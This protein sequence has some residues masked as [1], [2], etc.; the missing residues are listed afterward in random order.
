MAV[1]VAVAMAV[2]VGVGVAVVV[3]VVVL[4]LWLWELSGIA[5]DCTDT[6]TITHHHS[7]VYLRVLGGVRCG[8]VRYIVLAGAVRRVS[9][10]VR[11][12][13]WGDV[14]ILSLPPFNGVKMCQ[15]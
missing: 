3:A 7:A 9:G 15:K 4:W 11:R 5:I 2:G 12:R 1:A 14:A 13:V 10:W 6:A 8:C